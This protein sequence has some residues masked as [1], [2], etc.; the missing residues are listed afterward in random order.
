MK[1]GRLSQVKDDALCCPEC[2]L[3]ASFV[4]VQPLWVESNTGISLLR[5]VVAFQ[6]FWNCVM[7]RRNVRTVSLCIA[8]QVARKCM[9]SLRKELLH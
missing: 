1:L 5:D 3:E 7:M 8:L 2:K 6:P 4:T 9:R